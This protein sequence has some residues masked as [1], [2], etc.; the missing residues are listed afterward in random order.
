MIQ[1]KIEYNRKK[2]IGAGTCA[3]VAADQWEM[4]SSGKAKMKGVSAFNEQT[5]LFEKIIDE[6][7]FASNKKAADGCPKKVIHITNLETGEKII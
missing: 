3:A 6:K 4:E 2:C 5:Q 1:F 7:D